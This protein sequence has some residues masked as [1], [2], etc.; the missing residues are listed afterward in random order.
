M[1]IRLS[2]VLVL[3]ASIAMAQ[4]AAEV[5]VAA[6]ETEQENPANRTRIVWYIQGD[7]TAKYTIERDITGAAH[8]IVESSHGRNE[9]FIAQGV[10]YTLENNTWKKYTAVATAVPAPVLL[11]IPGLLRSNLAGVRELPTRVEGN[12]RF[13]VFQGALTWAHAAGELEVLLDADSG[14]LMRMAFKGQCGGRE[15][16]FEQVL[17]YDSGLRVTPPA[18][19]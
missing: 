1:M 3:T 10:L 17:E 4:T 11:D 14:R 12:D 8:F 18:V 16:S 15:C 6:F 5:V 7:S 9:F 2:L 19:P 13:R